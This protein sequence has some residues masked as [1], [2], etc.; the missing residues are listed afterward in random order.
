MI[1]KP[2]LAGKLS[3][4]ENDWNITYPVLC[5]PKLD[6]IRCLIVE[7]KARTRNFK[8]IPNNYIRSKL[9]SECPDGFDGELILEKTPFNKIASA[10]MS[11]NGEPNF[12]YVVFD[13]VKD[14]CN[15]SYKERMNDLKTTIIP[16]FCNR[17]LPIELNSI[18]EILAYENF[19]LEEGYEGIMLRT[20]ES[21]YKCGRSTLKQFWLIKL[22]RFHTAEAT[23]VGFEEKFNNVNEAEISELGYTKRSK[24]KC[25]MVAAETLGALI[26]KDIETGKTFNIGSGFDDKTRQLIW[27]S[28]EDYRYRIITYKSQKFGVKDKPRF[29]IFLEFREDI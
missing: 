15:K 22:K 23:I 5:T 26:V 20:P 14:S 13:Y 19:C 24:H 21:Q 16:Q 25:N 10:V 27:N 4:E 17:L 12:K 6:G 29:P 18:K 11:F 28:R 2:M 9:E 1:I 3:D 8:P 7:G